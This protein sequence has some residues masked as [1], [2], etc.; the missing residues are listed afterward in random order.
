MNCSCRGIPRPIK[1]KFGRNSNAI[2]KASEAFLSL[3]FCPEKDFTDQL[4]ADAESRRQNS[5][6]ELALAPIT[7]TLRG[8]LSAASRGIQSVDPIRSALDFD[9]RLNEKIREA[10]QMGNPSART[11]FALE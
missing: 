10:N 7:R 2:A 5:E 9:P 6:F 11:R 1:V 3:Q 4:V 8:A